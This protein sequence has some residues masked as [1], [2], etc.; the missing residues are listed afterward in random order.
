M[1]LGGLGLG[2]SIANLYTC[3]SILLNPRIDSETES[4][5]QTK[6]I[7]ELGKKITTETHTDSDKMK[8]YKLVNFYTGA[9]GKLCTLI[10]CAPSKEIQALLKV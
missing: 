1:Y 5:S 7:Y 8:F 10:E 9:G 6:K 4:G 2:G 3:M